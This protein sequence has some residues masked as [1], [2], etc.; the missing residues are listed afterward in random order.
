MKVISVRVVSSAK[1]D[2][3]LKENGEL[4]VYVKA[5]AV[6]GK[7][8]DAVVKLLAEFFGVRRNGVRIVK[9]VRSRNKMIEIDT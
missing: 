3:V 8:N 6:G 9:G 1:R 2:E 5:P 7:A 4:R